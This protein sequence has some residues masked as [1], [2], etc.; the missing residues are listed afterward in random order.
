MLE[1]NEVL[2][3]IVLVKYR[4]TVLS[5]PQTI[6]VTNAQTIYFRR[7]P[8]LAETLPGVITDCRLAMTLILLPP[9]I[10]APLSCF[11]MFALA[12]PLYSFFFST[13]S[14]IVK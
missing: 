4:V 8:L 6:S 1:N 10:A 9:N 11:L 3:E 2:G 7:D 13:F 5:H 12:S 14:V